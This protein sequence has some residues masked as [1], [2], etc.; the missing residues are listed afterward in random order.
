VGLPFLLFRIR[1]PLHST[2]F[3]FAKKYRDL[4]SYCS[5]IRGENKRNGFYVVFVCA[6]GKRVLIAEGCGD[7]GKEHVYCFCWTEN[8]AILFICLFLCV[9]FYVCIASNC[10]SKINV[11]SILQHRSKKF[12][13]GK[14][15]ILVFEC[16]CSHDQCF[17]LMNVKCFS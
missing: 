9:N 13:Q 12:C 10:F 11:I 14:S 16:K 3:S 6:Q 1:S 7:F 8:S 15:N 5:R 4:V 2:P 17:R